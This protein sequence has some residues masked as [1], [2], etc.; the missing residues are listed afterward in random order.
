MILI[1]LVLGDS[2][3]VGIVVNLPI[4]WPL[5][6]GC[7]GAPMTIRQMFNMF[8]QLS[9]D[10]F[11]AILDI[12]LDLLETLPPELVRLR[13][14][15]LGRGM[16]IVGVLVDDFVYVGL[17]FFYWIRKINRVAR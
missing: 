4:G 3:W 7:Y 17:T 15:R 11:H 14:F 10:L 1:F 5:G 12:F 13:G 8:L 6:D 16:D 9:L 2:F